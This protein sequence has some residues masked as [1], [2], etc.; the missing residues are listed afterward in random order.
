[1][2]F[3]PWQ[4]LGRALAILALATAAG[5]APA[6]QVKLGEGSVVTAVT[7][8][9]PGEFIWVPQVAPKG[10][11]LL[12][13]NLKNQRAMLYRN[14][15]PIGATTVSTGRP[16]YETPTG[17]F[18]I[19][20]KQVEHYSRTYDN[21]PMPYMHRLT[22]KGVALH[23]GNLPGHP[24]SHG[25]IRLPA[26]FA[27]LLYG[28]STLGM[29]VVIMDG[30]ET[31][32]MA[33]APQLV[34]LP[35]Q[36]SPSAEPIEWQ[37]DRSPSGPVSIIVSAADQ[38]AVVLRYGVQIGAAKVTIE[39][40]VSGTWA[41]ALRDGD[42]SGH[43]WVRLSLGSPDRPEAVADDEWSRFQVP[44]EFRRAVAS[45]VE[46]GTTIVVTS[47]SLAAGATGAAV[48]VADDQPPP[49]DGGSP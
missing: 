30:A 26:G 23:A 3:R 14:G 21:A 29:T 13:V 5:H 37:P 27:K 22:W 10:P 41:Y 16:G 28:V 44:D 34:R 7:S 47:D 45:V 49:S 32:R 6:Q 43:R 24:A 8:L 12:V 1:M 9:R 31:P 20:Q 35:T 40:P 19:L 48:T 42:G 11:L 46:P 4:V 36:P 33:P 25:C 2:T 17:V 18:T 15:V 38:R 39:G